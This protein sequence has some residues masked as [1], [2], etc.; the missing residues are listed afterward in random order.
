MLHAERELCSYSCTKTKDS[1]DDA[2]LLT[3]LR[4][5][6]IYI[7]YYII[8]GSQCAGL[9][10]VKDCDN[11]FTHTPHSL[12]WHHGHFSNELIT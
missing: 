7:T 9:H 11:T 12:L 4:F 6:H 2:Q 10:M 3:G 1:R 5:I 8:N